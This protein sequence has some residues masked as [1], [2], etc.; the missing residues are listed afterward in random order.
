M[1]LTPERTK[2]LLRWTKTL[3]FAAVLPHAGIG[4]RP[5][6]AEEIAEA[7]DGLSRVSGL[8]VAE[9]IA[10]QANSGGH[11]DSVTF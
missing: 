3:Y 1:A 11:Y 9:M 4:G 6:T 8:D 5:R 10:A 2:Q 7:K